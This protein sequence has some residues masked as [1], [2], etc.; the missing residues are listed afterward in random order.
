[1]SAPENINIRSVFSLI[2][3]ADEKKPERSFY[4]TLTGPQILPEVVQ[5]IEMLNLIVKSSG[6]D[7]N[8]VAKET[9]EILKN[10]LTALTSIKGQQMNMLT[11]QKSQINVNDNRVR[12]GF[13]NSVLPRPMQ[14]QQ[15]EE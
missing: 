14:S 13:M 11:T 4:R 8:E 10:S 6:G 12:R 15:R 9:L 3:V 2:S 7:D 5:K 1:M